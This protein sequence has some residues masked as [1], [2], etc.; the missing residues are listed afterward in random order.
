MKLLC[1]QSTRN[2]LCSNLYKS[3][4]KTACNTYIFSIGY[5]RTFIERLYAKFISLIHS[6]MRTKDAVLQDELDREIAGH[7]L[8]AEEH[9]KVLYSYTLL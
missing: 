2:L 1:L 7:F 9:C 4:T 8:A 6:G 3:L 5:L